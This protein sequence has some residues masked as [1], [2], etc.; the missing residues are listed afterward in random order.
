MRFVELRLLAR[1]WN[2]AVYHTNDSQNTPQRAF[3]VR[4]PEN[5]IQTRVEGATYGGIL[6]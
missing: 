4:I 2:S 6:F 3:T 5:L 1:C